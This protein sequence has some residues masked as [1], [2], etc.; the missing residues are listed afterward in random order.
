MKFR[1]KV[2]SDSLSPNSEYLYVDEGFQNNNYDSYRTAVTREP[3]EKEI[4]KKWY[5]RRAI[6]HL[7]FSLK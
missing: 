4:T 5:R 2:K 3:D 6:F 1:K 7:L